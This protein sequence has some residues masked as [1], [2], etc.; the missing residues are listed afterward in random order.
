MQPA[1]EVML[2]QALGLQSARL[3]SICGS[4]GKTSLMFALAREFVAAG[5]RILVTTTTKIAASEGRG[6]W[7]L[8]TAIDAS[9]V[10][11]GARQAVGAK[12]GAVIAACGHSADPNK[13]V[14]FAPGVVDELHDDG[15]FDRIL[16]EADGA[17]RKPLKAPAPYEPVF[18]AA[19][20]SVVMVAGVNGLGKPLN[21]DH[22]FRPHRWRE[23][24]GDLPDQPISPESLAMV[25]MHERGLARGAP[26]RAHKVLFLN[27]VDSDGRLEKARRVIRAIARNSGE[28]LGAIV[29]GVLRPRP[30]IVHVSG[31]TA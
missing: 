18:P 12:C 21:A 6:E 29:C 15:C 14:G 27:Q 7:P 11:A 2:A 16:V 17:L 30:G 13:L 4:G 1:P 31:N 19:S 24:T 23:L 20:D 26:P 8:I 28:S 10:V 25:V 9:A 5:E 22:L 3:V